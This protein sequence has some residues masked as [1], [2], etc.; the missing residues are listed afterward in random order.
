MI[1]LNIMHFECDVML[2]KFQTIN[3]FP[4]IECECDFF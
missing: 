3:Y 2:N 4:I 1:F